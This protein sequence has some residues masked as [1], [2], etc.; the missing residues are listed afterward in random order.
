MFGNNFG[1]FGSYSRAKRLPRDLHHIT[2]PGAVLLAESLDPYQT[3]DAAHLTYQRANVAKGRMAGQIRIRVRYGTCLGPW[4]DYLLMSPREMVQILE[5]TGWAVE[6][7]V[8]DGGPRYV[9]VITRI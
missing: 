8:S 5:G 2:A 4:F 9:A 1:L 6:R 7:V 3:N